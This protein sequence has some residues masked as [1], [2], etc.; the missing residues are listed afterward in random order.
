MALGRISPFA[1]P[2]PHFLR[3]RGGGPC[4]SGR[5]GGGGRIGS[6]GGNPIAAQLAL[7][8]MRAD[9]P[10]SQA[11][12][13]ESKVSAKLWSDLKDLAMGGNHDG[14]M[15]KVMGLDETTFWTLYAEIYDDWQMVGHFTYALLDA[16][17][18]YTRGAS[19]L[20]VGAGTGLATR[21][22]LEG[23]YSVYS[24]EPCQP[25]LD[26][27]RRAVPEH[28]RLKVQ[29]KPLECA[30]L[31]KQHFD[32][33]LVRNVLYLVDDPRAFLTKVARHA[34]AITISG[35]NNTMDSER[36]AAK[37]GQEV[38]ERSLHD[39]LGWRLALVRPTQARLVG[40]SGAPKRFSLDQIKALLAELGYTNV[41]TANNDHF[42]GMSYFVA[43]A[44][45]L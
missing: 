23:G 44:K 13:S 15:A 34:D 45:P 33:A 19:V 5:V 2:R 22:L 14:L 31:G 12:G 38:Q 41:V 30:R 1:I 7:A 17:L 25:M 35:P 26:H 43:A 3:G 21:A 16:H 40:A 28:P 10:S 42:F 29:A 9:Y 39:V 32:S 8:R 24:L 11:Q 27:L 18:L 6:R 20:D 36:F 37:V 4:F